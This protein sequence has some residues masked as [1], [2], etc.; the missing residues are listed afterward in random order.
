MCS[1]VYLHLR[2]CPCMCTVA[3][4]YACAC[5]LTYP[6]CKAHEPLLSSVTSLA[7]SYFST[8]H[9]DN[10]FGIVIE[11]KM[12]VSLKLLSETFLIIGRV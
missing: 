6:A 9:K 8:P 4:S 2:A 3:W 10:I 1:H 12:S 11:H 7:P 5:S